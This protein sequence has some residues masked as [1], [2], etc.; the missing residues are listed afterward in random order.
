M[1]QFGRSNLIRR[2]KLGCKSMTD[3][4]RKQS[5]DQRESHESTT[6][7]TK[8]TYIYETIVF[9]EFTELNSSNVKPMTI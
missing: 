2:F 8:L 1:N 5:L 6:Q 7:I 9:A 4:Q 3:T